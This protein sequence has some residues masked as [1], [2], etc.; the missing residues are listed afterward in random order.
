MLDIFKLHYSIDYRHLHVSM[1]VHVL[2]V[3]DGGDS[4]TE[5]LCDPSKVESI[6]GRFLG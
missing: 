1:I 6:V 5:R 3:V 2:V 4:A